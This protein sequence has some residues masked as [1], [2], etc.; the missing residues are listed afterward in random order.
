MLRASG[1]CA[2]HTD[3]TSS[4]CDST[5]DSNSMALLGGGPHRREWLRRDP[6]DRVLSSLPP[7]HLFLCFLT[8]VR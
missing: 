8:A 1:R 2:D 4:K 3:R 6:G 5:E 7:L